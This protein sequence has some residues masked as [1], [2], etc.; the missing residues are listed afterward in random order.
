[1]TVRSK[2]RMARHWNNEVK[3]MTDEPERFSMLFYFS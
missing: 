3:L 1:M 2:E